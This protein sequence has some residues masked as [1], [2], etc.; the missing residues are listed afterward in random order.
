MYDLLSHKHEGQLMYIGISFL[1]GNMTFPPLALGAI[2]I[3][4]KMFHVVLICV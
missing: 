4:S 3:F 2:I 1:G